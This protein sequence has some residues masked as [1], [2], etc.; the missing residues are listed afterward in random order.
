MLKGENREEYERLVEELA[1]QDW[2]ADRVVHLWTVT[3][4]EVVELESMQERGFFSLLFLAQALGKQVLSESLER[5]K[6]SGPIQI[7]VVSNN[8]QSVNG[9]ENL[10]PE[11][12]TVLG[13]CRVIGQEYPNINCRSI[14]VVLHGQQAIIGKQLIDEL[15]SESSDRIVAYRGRYRWVQTYEHVTLDRT[16]VRLRERGVYV[17]TGGLGG[18]GLVLAEHL[19]EVVHAKLVLIGRSAFPKRIEWEHWLQS[20]E[21]TDAVSVKIRKLQTLEQKGGEIFVVQADVTDAAQ[22]QDVFEQARRRF[23]RLHGVIHAAGNPPEGLSQ[24]KSREQ[25][26]EIL[27]PKVRGTAVL[28]SLCKNEQLDFIVLCSSIGSI[29]ALPG[30]ID[31]CAANAFLD[32]Y[33][34]SKNIDG[35]TY[36]VAINWDGWEEVGMATNST[37]SSDALNREYSVEGMLSSEG[38]EVLDRILSGDLPQVLVSVEDLPS[39][40]RRHDALTAETSLEKLKHDRT[41]HSTHARP[42]LKTPYVAPRNEVEQIIAG[43]WQTLLGIDQ[44]GVEDNFFDLGGHSLLATQVMSRLHQRLGVD[45]PLRTLFEARTIAVFAARVDEL[46]RGAGEDR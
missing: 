17:I 45:V 16:P 9:E 33:A 4:D 36:T 11:K 23:G 46:A 26:A 30:R 10:Q 43:I 25:A 37:L 20:H 35:G 21:E 6:K 32:A 5:D 14:D 2:R 7:T 18:V 29:L 1:E 38:V 8:M 44:I 19:V 22:M 39:R 27:S 31:Y 28:D 41:I 40:V 15:L 13:P 24:L 42:H 34:Q 12:A 3:S